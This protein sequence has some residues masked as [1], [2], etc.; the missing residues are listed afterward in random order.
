MAGEIRSGVHFGIHLGGDSPLGDGEMG[1]PGQEADGA[2][3]KSVGGRGF[4]V[5]VMLRRVRLARGSQRTRR[6]H[7]NS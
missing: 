2:A 6:V 4:D 1:L 7:G 5:A 3:V